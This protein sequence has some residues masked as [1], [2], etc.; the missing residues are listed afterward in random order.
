MTLPPRSRSGAGGGDVARALLMDCAVYRD[1]VVFLKNVLRFGSSARARQQGQPPCM[2]SEANIALSLFRRGAWRPHVG[3]IGRPRRHLPP[4]QIDALD[5]IA[6]ATYA[7][8]L[9]GQ[10][11]IPDLRE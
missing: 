5:G 10:R 1:T 11:P 9:D 3:G 8:N 7:F 6:D 4:F 2:T